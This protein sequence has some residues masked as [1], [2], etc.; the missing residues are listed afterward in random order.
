M[1]LDT[2][3]EADMTHEANKNLVRRLVE[4]VNR[5]DLNEL[6][7]VAAGEFASAARRW[8][9]PF[10][11]SFPDFEMQIV[12]LVAEDDKVVAHFKCS[13]TH[14]ADWLGIGAINNRFDDVDEIYIFRVENGRLAGATGVEDNLARM[15][16]LGIRFTP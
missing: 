9:S 7:H 12:D 16:Q 15:R 3:F 13:G 11:G 10:Q 6:D 5:R 4:A 14:R 1:G 8:V 2:A